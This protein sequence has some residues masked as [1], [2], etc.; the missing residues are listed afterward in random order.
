M[1]LLYEASDICKTTSFLRVPTYI[2]GR[3]MVNRGKPELKPIE[4]DEKNKDKTYFCVACGN[5]ATQT[6]FFKVEGATIVER[7]CDKCAKTVG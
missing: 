7:Y 5:P 2:R 4:R 1:L 3:E 6:A